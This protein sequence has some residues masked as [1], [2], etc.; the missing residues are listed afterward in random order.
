[1]SKHFTYLVFQFCFVYYSSAYSFFIVNLSDMYFSDDFH[2]LRLLLNNFGLFTLQTK[3][4]SKLSNL[5]KPWQVEICSYKLTF[6]Q[7]KEIKNESTIFCY[8][9]TNTDYKVNKPGLVQ[10]NLGTQWHRLSGK[11]SPYSPS[12]N[13]LNT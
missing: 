6:N 1:M 4:G 11:F 13:L 2:I 7:R 10:Q 12:T 5:A 8:C 9:K 3:Q